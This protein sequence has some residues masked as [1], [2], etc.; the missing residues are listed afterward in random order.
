MAKMTKRYYPYLVGWTV[1]VLQVDAQGDAAYLRISDA[2]AAA[3]L[4]DLIQVA[5]GTY[6]ERL[7]L[8]K[9]VSICAQPQSAAVTVIW[10]TSEP[11]Q[12]V[13]QCSC[14]GARIQG[15][16][17]RH[18][19][20][21]VATNYAVYVAGGDLTLEGCD[22]S[23]QSGSGVG[24]E[25]GS[26]Q[27]RRCRIH[28]CARHGIALFGDLFGAEGGGLVQD[29]MIR[30]NKQNG[31]L[32]RDGAAPTLRHNTVTGNAGYGVL[33]KACAG[34]YQDN[35]IAG[36]RQGSVLLDASADLDSTDLAEQNQLDRPAT[37]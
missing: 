16:T 30:D 4:G 37:T 2:I 14:A 20:P 24:V 35:K 19:S 7:I 17:L 6:H 33:L 25:G 22:I 18:R 31:V 11:Y 28:D 29:C 34:E 21:S 1:Q 3:Q 8:D 32:V 10:E 15:L 5:A 12:A 13:V 23:S 26:P 9:A 36:N 27:I